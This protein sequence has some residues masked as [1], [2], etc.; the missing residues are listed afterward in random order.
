MLVILAAAFQGGASQQEG[1]G[2]THF[3][4]P[5]VTEYNLGFET[6]S[7]HQNRILLENLMVSQL[8]EKFPTFDATRQFDTVFTGPHNLPLS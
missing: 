4:P 3:T 2:R 7:S 8:V 5:C 6:I 1:S